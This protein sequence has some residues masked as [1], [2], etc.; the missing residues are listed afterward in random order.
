MSLMSARRPSESVWG[1]V[2][3]VED[4]VEERLSEEEW[5]RL[6]TWQW[7]EGSG[8][9]EHEDRPESLRGTRY[10]FRPACSAKFKFDV[11]AGKGDR[12]VM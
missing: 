9:L 8:S 3:K 10:D 6:M 1:F 2:A 4:D 11:I 7:N 5:R 12:T